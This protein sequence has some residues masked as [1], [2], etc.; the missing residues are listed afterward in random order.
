V[1]HRPA[2]AIVCTLNGTAPRRIPETSGP[3]PSTALDALRDGGKSRRR[4]L[5]PRDAHAA[6]GS[7]LDADLISVRGARAACGK[8]AW[9]AVRRVPRVRRTRPELKAATVSG[10]TATV[11]TAPLSTKRRLILW[12]RRPA[13]G[14]TL[15][16]IASGSAFATHLS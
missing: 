10:S 12:G 3:Q 5:E 4:D 6:R 11:G 8:H 15:G 9:I 13:K 1:L 16:P 2:G 7:D 14:A